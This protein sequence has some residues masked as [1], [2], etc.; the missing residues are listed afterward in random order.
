MYF[1]P[2][3]HTGIIVYGNEYYF[4]AGRSIQHS[5]VGS[6]PHGTPLAVVDLGVTNVTKYDFEMY[7]Q[8]ISQHYTAETYSMLSCNCNHFS[9]EVSQFLVGA[10]IPEYI[11]QLPNQILSSPMGALMCKLLEFNNYVLI[12]GIFFLLE[13]KFNLLYHY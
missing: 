1:V 4:G 11:L 10:T 3:R 13:F 6:M 9:N 5:P 2:L 8:E 12:D 7:L